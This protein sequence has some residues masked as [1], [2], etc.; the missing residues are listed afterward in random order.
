MGLMIIFSILQAVFG[1]VV[2]LVIE[3]R[4]FPKLKSNICRQRA[5]IGD[6]EQAFLNEVLKN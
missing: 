2:L 4:I 6:S 1:I 3:S 5:T